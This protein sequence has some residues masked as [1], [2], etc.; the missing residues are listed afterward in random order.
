MTGRPSR[1]SF[2]VVIFDRGT[3]TFSVEGPIWKEKVCRDAV[4]RA[5]GDGRDVGYIRYRDGPAS[6]WRRSAAERFRQASG[7][8]RV[9]MGGILGTDLRKPG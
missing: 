7:F 1:H 5:R 2:L 4:A 9:A 6:E 3:G 8:R